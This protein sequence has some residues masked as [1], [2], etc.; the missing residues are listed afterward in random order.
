M[1]ILG[2][3]NTAMRDADACYRI[4]F[5][6]PPADRRNEYHELRVQVDKPG[7]QVRTTAGYYANVQH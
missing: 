6:A 1:D 5:Q 7:A 2:E 3:L 4:T